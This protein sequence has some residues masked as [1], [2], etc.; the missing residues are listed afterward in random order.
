MPSLTKITGLGA[1]TT[2]K[3]K[4]DKGRVT[5]YGTDIVEW[6][7]K[8]VCLNTGGFDTATTRTRMN[9]AAHVYDLGYRVYREKGKL[10]AWIRATGEKVQFVDDGVT[11]RRP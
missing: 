7:E 1:N 10:W 6:N 9:Q 4:N 5:L 8:E 3:I 2:V 11:L